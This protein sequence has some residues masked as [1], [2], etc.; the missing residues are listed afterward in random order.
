MTYEEYLDE[1]TTLIT[2]KYLLSDEAAIK[3]VVNA[4]AGNYFVVHDKNDTMR[5]LD[6]AHKDAKVLYEASLKKAK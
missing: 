2:E 6:R 3:L 5:N 1:V 4:Q